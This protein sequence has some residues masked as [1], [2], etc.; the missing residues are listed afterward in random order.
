MPSSSNLCWKVIIHG[1]VKFLQALWAEAWTTFAPSY[2]QDGCMVHS[3]ERQRSFLCLEQR[4][5]LLAIQCNKDDVFVWQKAGRFALYQ[6]LGF[7]NLGITQLW[8]KPTM[9]TSSTSTACV[10]QSV[11][12]IKE[13]PTQTWSSRGLL[14]YE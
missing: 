10:T 7:P 6:R 12:R 5:G 9:C 11:L 1:F 8:H 3:L 13:E 4:A 2:L 14:C